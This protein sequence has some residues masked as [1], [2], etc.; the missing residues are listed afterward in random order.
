MKANRPGAPSCSSAWFCLSLAASL[1]ALAAA[2][3]FL[4]N[5]LHAQPSHSHCSTRKVQMSPHC[6][7]G[8]SLNLGWSQG[9]CPGYKSR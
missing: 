6:Q 1:A 5:T 8:S 4:H 3:A 7:V 2:V 9:T